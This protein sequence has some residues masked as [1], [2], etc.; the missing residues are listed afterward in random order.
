MQLIPTCDLA[1]VG[2]SETSCTARTDMVTTQCISIRGAMA[3][4]RDSPH[5]VVTLTHE[6]VQCVPLVG[7]GDNGGGIGTI[8]TPSKG[9]EREGAI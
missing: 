4:C 1:E 8:K 5:N 9:K 6:K 3:K 2:C 7:V